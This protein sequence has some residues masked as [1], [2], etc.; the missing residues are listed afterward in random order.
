MENARCLLED[1]V[2]GK[3]GKSVFEDSSA[4]KG[5]KTLTGLDRV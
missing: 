1:G 4:S 2:Q 3:V 5:K